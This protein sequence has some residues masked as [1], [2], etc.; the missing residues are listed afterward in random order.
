[1]RRV[2]AIGIMLLKLNGSGISYWSTIRRD[3]VYIFGMIGVSFVFDFLF[4]EDEIWK[5]CILRH[6]CLNKPY[7]FLC[8]GNIC[9]Y[10]DNNIFE[11]PTDTEKPGI[12]YWIN[13][14]MFGIDLR[15][16]LKSD[17]LRYR[18]FLKCRQYI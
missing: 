9:V 12:F 5:N 8:K 15:P 16:Y 6:L 7:L 14:S 10:S 11:L 17:I 2:F 1:M 13:R 3:T 4:S 18:T